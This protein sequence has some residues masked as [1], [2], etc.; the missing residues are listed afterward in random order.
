MMQTFS[1]KEALIASVILFLT[2]GTV[3]PQFRLISLRLSPV[4]A[5]VSPEEFEVPESV[6]RG[7]TVRLDGSSSMAKVNQALK[8]R[9]EQQVS[10]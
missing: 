4:L 7:T 2:L 8:E 1:K 3:S 5:Q 9:F 10:Q 6:P